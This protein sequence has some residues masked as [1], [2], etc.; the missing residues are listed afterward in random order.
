M[1]ALKAVLPFVAILAL[2]WFLIIRPSQRRQRALTQMRTALQPGDRVMLTSGIFGTVRSLTGD[3]A[4]VEVAD[5][6][7]LTVASGAIASQEP[8]ESGPAG[9]DGSAPAGEA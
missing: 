9:A 2:F 1:E 6:V 3:R 7:V 8:A 4:E 5:G